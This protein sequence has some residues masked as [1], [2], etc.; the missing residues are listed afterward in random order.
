MAFGSTM[1]GECVQQEGMV[2]VPGGILC[3]GY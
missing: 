3:W 2:G 1:K